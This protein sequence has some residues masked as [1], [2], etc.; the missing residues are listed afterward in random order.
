[1]ATL[2]SACLEDAGVIPKPRICGE[3][4]GIRANPGNIVCNGSDVWE[5]EMAQ[6]N[7]CEWLDDD[8]EDDE[9]EDEDEDYEPEEELT[10]EVVLDKDRNRLRCVHTRGLWWQ[11]LPELYVAPPL[12]FSPP[13]GCDW[14]R[15]AFVLA[16]GLIELGQL[17]IE[18]DSFEISTHS[19]TVAGWPIE[20]WPGKQHDPTDWLAVLMSREVDTVI[21]VECSFWDDRPEE[22]R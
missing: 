13:N 14:G 6:Q 7:H 18:A 21:Q 19:S 3:P 11:G 2:S 20:M 8:D 22:L 9:L 10:V 16:S 15:L 1:M 5:K 4:F 17:L 12:D